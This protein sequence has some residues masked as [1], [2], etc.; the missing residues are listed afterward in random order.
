MG[1]RSG[2]NNIYTLRS[3]LTS[4]ARE[5]DSHLHRLMETESPGHPEPT[6]MELNRRFRELQELVVERSA[7]GSSQFEVHQ[8]S[9]V[10]CVNHERRI[11]A[12]KNTISHFHI[13]T[14]SRS[15]V[16]RSAHQGWKLMVY[17][18]AISTGGS[19]RACGCLL[20]SIRTSKTGSRTRSAIQLLP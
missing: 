5:K 3:S 9:S 2:E 1:C 6:P 7:L 10:R 16:E 12:K 17:H 8:P 18:S 13:F 19:P 20:P 4:K 15:Q 14:F 11:T